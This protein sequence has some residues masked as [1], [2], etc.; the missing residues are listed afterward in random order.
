M[1]LLKKGRYAAVSIIQD[2]KGRILSVGVDHSSALYGL[3]ADTPEGS[4]EVKE[5]KIWR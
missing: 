4:W 2:A 5:H 3:P 1:D